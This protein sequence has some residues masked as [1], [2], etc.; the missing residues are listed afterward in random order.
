MDLRLHIA[1]GQCESEMVCAFAQQWTRWLA[2]PGPRSTVWRVSCGLFRHGKKMLKMLKM[3][4][5]SPVWRWEKLL[6]FFGSQMLIS[7][8][9][10]PKYTLYQSLTEKVSFVPILLWELAA[11]WW[12]EMPWGPAFLAKTC[13]NPQKNRRVVGLYSMSSSNSCSTKA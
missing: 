11:L 6:T 12:D 8:Q 13:W 9:Q 4:G 2:P 10:L 3:T 5:N 1:P 7:F